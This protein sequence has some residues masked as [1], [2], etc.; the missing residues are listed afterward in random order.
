MALRV[1][2]GNDSA[3]VRLINATDFD[4]ACMNTVPS[5]PMEATGLVA[6]ACNCC[7]M[8]DDEYRSKVYPHEFKMQGHLFPA[9]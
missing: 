8:F 5:P 6:I 1:C 7:L 9:Y 2:N 3:L 4:D